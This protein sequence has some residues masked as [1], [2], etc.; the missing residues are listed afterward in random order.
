MY[1]AGFSR[2]L[3]WITGGVTVPWYPCPIRLVSTRF[4]AAVCRS[5]CS[6]ACS[7]S[8]GP[9][10]SGVGL[11]DAGRH[12]L[13]D[14]RVEARGADDARA[15]R[16]SPTGSGRCGGGWRSR[17]D[18]RRIPESVN[19]ATL[20]LLGEELNYT[21]EVVSR[22]TRTASCSTPSTCS[23]GSR[24]RGRRGH[25]RARP[26]VVTV[27]GH[28]DHG[29]T[30]L[31]DALRTANVVD[32]G[33]GQDLQMVGA[34]VDGVLRKSAAT[35][36]TSSGSDTIAVMR[37][38]IILAV[39]MAAAT[40]R[41]TSAS[42]PSF[43]SILDRDEAAAGRR[44]DAEGVSETEGGDLAMAMVDVTN[45]SHDLAR[46]LSRR[47]A[48]LSRVGRSSCSS[49]PTSTHAE[50]ERA[51]RRARAQRDDRTSPTTTPRRTSSTS[52]PTRRPDPARRPRAATIH[53]AAPRHQPPLPA[54]GYTDNVSAMMKPWSFGPYGRDCRSSARTARTATSCT[55][56]RR[57]PRCCS[58][59]SAPR[60]PAQRRDDGAARAPARA[61][62]RRREPGERVHR[63]VAARRTRSSGR[64]PA[65]RAKS[66]TTPRTSSCRTAGSFIS[67]SSPAAPRMT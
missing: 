32:K 64:K 37:I 46:R 17:R 51:G 8:A 49:W 55:A 54:L 63:R 23:S 1:Q 33:G 52:S 25:A 19:D 67:S 42:S 14:Q 27:M 60:A 58:G 26:P 61:A 29:K 16:R 56:E 4:F 66:A 50:G 20:Q 21:V 45:P 36:A 41:A 34:E 57:A 48:V 5:R 10:S 31:L 35:A 22:R 39:L 28:V 38:R 2:M 53:R 65:G 9:Q 3:R 59:S 24:R 13:V 12:G 47:R 30:K 18:G 62:A 43:R 44:G 7:E 15:S 40:A 11:A 6:A